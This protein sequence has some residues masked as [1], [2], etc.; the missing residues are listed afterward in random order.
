MA[1][2][3]MLSREIVFRDSFIEMPGDSQRLYFYLV[4]Q[5]DDEG[6]V[7]N[8]KGIAAMWHIPE[9]CL[10]ILIAKRF[11]ISFASGCIVIRHWKQQN[12][13]AKK[14]MTPT[15]WTRERSMLA[16]INGE[17]FLIGMEELPEQL[18]AP[19][20]E[21]P[22]ENF[23]GEIFN[24][25][26]NFADTVQCSVVEC[27]TD[28][29]SVVQSSRC[30]GTT[31]TEKA[32]DDSDDFGPPTLEELTA[33]CL[34]RRAEGFCNYF[35]PQKFMLVNEQRDWKGKDGRP[36]RWKTLVKMWELRGGAKDK[37]A[38]MKQEAARNGSVPA[39]MTAEE[40]RKMNAYTS[41]VNRFAMAGGANEDQI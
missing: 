14:R 20:E 36:I 38:W 5:A 10:K 11:V 21:T 27:S 37:E 34:Q 19:P 33:Y 17:Y 1:T 18:P 4:L 40:V 25:S 29:D 35:D 24:N 7:G 3:R 31:T 26:E 16:E 8:P 15:V 23:T 2:R 41:L 9:D 39:D 32:D 12:Q 28:Q 30:D 6:F 22:P 13:I